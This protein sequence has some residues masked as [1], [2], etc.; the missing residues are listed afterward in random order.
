MM[1][2]TSK[3]FP[4]RVHFAAFVSTSLAIY[5]FTH[6]I[7]TLDVERWGAS[8]IENA[9]R[10][11]KDMSA[12]SGKLFKMDRNISSAW[13]R[14]HL[15]N[16]DEIELHEEP[17]SI[18]LIGVV[19]TVFSNDKVHQI[20]RNF[21]AATN[22]TELVIV[23][24]EGLYKNIFPQ[25]LLS[26]FR[27]HILDIR[28]QEKLYPELSRFLPKNSFS[29]KNL[30]YL[31]AV[32]LG[33]CLIWDFDDDNDSSSLHI[34]QYLMNST[35]GTVEVQNLVPVLGCLS[36]TVEAVNPY[37]LFGPHQYAWPRGYPIE[38]TEKE[39]FPILNV[40]R[41]CVNN[42]VDVIQV[43]QKI[44][45]D[46]DAIWRLQNK[47]P[48][49]WLVS[50]LLRDD[51]V[52]INPTNFAP[53]NAQSTLISRKAFWSL[54]L[55][56][57]VH[58]RVSDIWRSFFMQTVAKHIESSVGFFRPNVS[59]HRNTHNYL[60]DFNAEKPLYERS[61]ELLRFLSNNMTSLL[62]TEGD[63]LD[64]LMAIYVAVGTNS[65]FDDSFHDEINGLKFWIK[66]LRKIYKAPA[67]VSKNAISDGEL[68]QDWAQRLEEFRKDTKDVLNV[69][70]INHA[71]MSNI[72]ILAATNP[73][74][75]NQIYF[76][77]G[78]DECIRVSGL[79]VNCIS[80]DKAGLYAYESIFNAYQHANTYSYYIFTH[81]DAVVRLKSLRK[82]LSEGFPLIA[83]G[84]NHPLFY[85]AIHDATDTWP[86]NV[87]LLKSISVL[88]ENW[89]PDCTSREFSTFWMRG[90]ADFFFATNAAMKIL[91]KDSKKLR[92][93]ETFLENAVHTLFLNCITNVRNYS[94]F[95]PWDN[96]RFH[97]RELVTE[98]CNSMNDVAHPVKIGTKQGIE[99]YIKAKMC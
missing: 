28:D 44:D 94:L 67:L 50:N 51:I 69:V 12:T 92:W 74:Y 10:Q 91:L 1:G 93:A 73:E 99:S 30:G 21:L 31:Y 9:I 14:Q 83:D 90:Q 98:F 34:L 41:D 85:T 66:E 29:R 35:N 33:A 2:A 48:L 16:D 19:T 65:L 76:T 97:P 80:D 82:F 40:A 13:I 18:D 62:P 53:Y 47:L 26:N 63:A 68:D 54:Y 43:L 4:R 22:H 36:A 42:S 39:H 49:S 95:T 15:M 24:D 11:G 5:M 70:H 45:P 32:S 72:P 61:G 96:L 17:C 8:G 25:E 52:V 7:Y 81:D 56:F 46:V 3:I 60:A 37:L 55:P 75:T 27:V 58:G 87:N 71:H 86:W 57:S 64:A 23:L 89:T 59:H 84:K 77:P 20:F 78:V 79:N 88:G 38:L 6:V